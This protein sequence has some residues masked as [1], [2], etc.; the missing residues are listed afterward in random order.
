MRCVHLQS[1]NVGDVKIVLVLVCG[2]LLTV[3]DAF[4]HSERGKEKK[5]KAKARQRATHILV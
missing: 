2:S 5:M 1:Y 4:K 3:L